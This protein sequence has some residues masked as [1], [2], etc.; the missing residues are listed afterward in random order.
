MKNSPTTGANRRWSDRPGPSSREPFALPA[1][2]DPLLAPA[3]DHEDDVEELEEAA[4]EAKDADVK[5]FAATGPP[6]LRE[7]LAT[8]RQVYDKVK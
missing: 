4:E 6:L 3:R 8:A 1:E 7:H 5:R 2:G